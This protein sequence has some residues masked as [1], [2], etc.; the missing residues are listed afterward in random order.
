M[1]AEVADKDAY[2]TGEKI[3]TAKAAVEDHAEL[4]R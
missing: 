2:R 4:H 1:F 3:R